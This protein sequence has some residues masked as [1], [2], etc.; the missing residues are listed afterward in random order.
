[1]L[2]KTTNVLKLLFKVLARC[3]RRRDL[4]PNLPSRSGNRPQMGGQAGHAEVNKYY[5]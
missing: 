1:M 4:R 2:L 3:L 5:K